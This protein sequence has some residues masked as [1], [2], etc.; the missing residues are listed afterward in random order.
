MPR[1]P[2]RP[3]EHVRGVKIN[4]HPSAW[5]ALRRLAYEQRTTVSEQVRRAVDAY[6]AKQK[7]KEVKRSR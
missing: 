4:V 7:R 2:I 6:L 5:D 1:P 3:A